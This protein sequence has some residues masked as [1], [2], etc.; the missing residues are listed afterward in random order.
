MHL[1]CLTCSAGQRR[2]RR[3][4]A[5]SAASRKF[6]ISSFIDSPENMARHIRNHR[7]IEN[8]LHWVLAVASVT[9]LP[10]CIYNNPSTAHFNFS[11]ELLERLAQIS[12]IV[13]VKIPLPADRDFQSELARLRNSA[14]A[15]SAVGYRG[16]RGCADALLA[17]A[18]GWFSVVGGL[19]PKPTMK[20]TRE[21][22]PGG[23][24]RRPDRSDPD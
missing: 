22:D 11:A 7:Q 3:S 16:D 6:Y 17:G 12:N 10:L 15:V 1:C 9:D 18:D 13:A 4:A 21:T 24:G 2:T 19:L 5:R 14:P 20:L 8:S 23:D